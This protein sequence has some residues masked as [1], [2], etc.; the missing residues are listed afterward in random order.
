MG[1]AG[2]SGRL[3]PG[4]AR[5]EA[6]AAEMGGGLRGREGDELERERVEAFERGWGKPELVGERIA[7]RSCE[8]RT[9]EQQ[10]EEEK[11]KEVRTLPAGAALARFRVSSRRCTSA[12][13]RLCTSCSRLRIRSSV[14]SERSASVPM[15]GGKRRGK[16]HLAPKEVPRLA[17]P[18]SAC[19]GPIP[20]LQ[21]KQAVSISKSFG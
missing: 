14:E 12:A 13:W 19:R 1:L 5:L 11:G 17:E 2:E 20:P 8:E 4:R 18:P 15:G 6:P 3:E 10:V 21:V 16:A 9:G 7:D